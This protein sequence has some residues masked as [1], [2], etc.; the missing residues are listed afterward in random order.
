MGVGEYL[1]FEESSPERHEYVA[2][3]VYA[4]TGATL[5][6]SLIVQNLSFRLMERARGGRCRVHTQNLKLRVGDDRIY[7]PDVLVLCTALPG[8]TLVVAD[9]CLVVEVTSPSTARVDRGEK[10]DA[11]RRVASLGTYLVVDE[12]RRR[13]D[14]HWRDA[15]GAWRREEYAGQGTGPVACPE[16]TGL[17]LDEIYEGVDVPGVA[18]PDPAEYEA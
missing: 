15:A 17:S 1:R 4:M 11:Y 9:P 12:R 5:R 8:D 7:Y 3:E 13:V 14:R 16:A 10:L 6:H 2:G 18:E